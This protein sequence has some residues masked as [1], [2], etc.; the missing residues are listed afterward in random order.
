[1]WWLGGGEAI[2]G[3]P[4]EKA[5]GLVRNDKRSLQLSAKFLAE[6]GAIPDEAMELIAKPLIPSWLYRWFGERG[7]KRQA[8]R[9]GTRKKRMARPFR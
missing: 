5:C 8:K 2:A 6:G 1:V 4:L 9:Y 7:W 3:K